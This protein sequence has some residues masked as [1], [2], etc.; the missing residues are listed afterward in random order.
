MKAN[1]LACIGNHPLMPY[2]PILS[3]LCGTVERKASRR[4]LDLSVNIGTA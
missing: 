3:I 4:R 2:I 1:G